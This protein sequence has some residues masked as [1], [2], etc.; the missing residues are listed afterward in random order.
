MGFLNT[1]RGIRTP[2]KQGRNLLLYP[3]ELSVQTY[4]Y[5]IPYST[6]FSVFLAIDLSSFRNI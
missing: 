1:P 3:T 2:D 4:V 6:S 5:I